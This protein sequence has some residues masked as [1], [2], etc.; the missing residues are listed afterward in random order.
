MTT[1]LGNRLVPEKEPHNL[2]LT[3]EEAALVVRIGM[4]VAM[5][6]I[7]IAGILIASL[8]A[9]QVFDVKFSL[10]PVFIICTI[11]ILYNLVLFW[12]A[13]GLTVEAGGSVTQGMAVPLRRLLQIPKPASMV[14]DK[15]TAIGDIHIGLDLV[16]LT[17]LLHFTGGIENPFIFYFVLHVII[18]GILLHS[19]VAYAVATAAI[20]LVF[21]LVG[22]EY[23]GI[24]PHVHLEGFASVDLYRQETYII[25]ILIALVTCLYGSAYMVTHVSGELRKRQREV[26]ALEERGLK[27]KAKELEEA[28]KE[29]VKLEEGRKHL[30]RFLAI[31]S[32]DLKAPLSAVQSYLQLM[33]GGFVGEMAEKQKH[34]MERSSK[35]VDELLRLISDLLDISRIEAGQI[36]GEMEKISLPQ[37][38]ESSIE[39]VRALAK[40]NKIS[41]VVE[42]PK[43]LPK[44]LASGVRLQQVITNLLTNAIKFT[45]EKGE[46]KVRVTDRG[47]YVQV[48]VMDTGSGIA[49]EDLPKIFN[50]FYRGGDREKTG[51]GL[52]LSIAR[53][54]VEA[55][56]GIVW[57]ESPNPDDK[58][59]RGSKFT[60]TL[61]KGLSLPDTKQRKRELMRKEKHKNGAQ[62]K[63]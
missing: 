12:Q 55:H 44:F 59:A 38:V 17:A 43:S 32:H 5:R 57:A 14:I 37:T 34:M 7:A 54:I 29:L 51:T 28:T 25:G 3:P 33:L 24:I 39:S 48:E 2:E 61:S 15:A 60:L 41:L 53:R 16:A 40:E 27:R 47:K 49:I 20:F 26:V 10:L 19:R 13:R 18:S 46:I 35:R 52:G 63:T 56:R 42:A 4:F 50:D 31:A 6:W 11:M 45:P 8:L 22:L 36:V 58:A 30:L 62:L 9:T 1:G 21:L 23:G